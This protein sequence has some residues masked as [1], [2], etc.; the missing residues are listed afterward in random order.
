MSPTS[1]PINARVAR[2]W[3]AAT[4]L[5]TVWLTATPA[6]CDPGPGT[7]R[8]AASTLATPAWHWLQQVLAELRDWSSVGVEA[9]HASRPA[10]HSIAGGRQGARAA[11][12][13]ATDDC[14]S[15]GGSSGGTSGATGSGSNDP[16][17]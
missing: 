4:L 12:S 3:L 1:L 8:L 17:G 10:A 9:P 15:G 16:N 6:R 5:M 11:G 2:P 7:T 14:S 13:S